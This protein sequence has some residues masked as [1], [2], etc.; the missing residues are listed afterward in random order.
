MVTYYS[1]MAPRKKRKPAPPAGV[2]VTDGARAMYALRVLDP[3]GYRAKIRTALT[4]TRS[5]QD[6]A[7]QLGVPRRSLE[8]WLETDPSLRDGIVLPSRG[9]PKK[10]AKQRVVKKSTKPNVGP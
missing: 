6:A 9:K 8:R 10:D 5:V 1:D 7:D 4:K 3:D 2:P